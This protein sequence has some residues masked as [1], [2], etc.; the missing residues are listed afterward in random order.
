MLN[1]QVDASGGPILDAWISQSSASLS[2]L[3]DSADTGGTLRE[4]SSGATR[5]GQPHFA[6]FRRDLSGLASRPLGQG[7]DGLAGAISIRESCIYIHT[8]AC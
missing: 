1:S 6:V 8:G 3:N 4:Y 7:L 2:G 5:Y